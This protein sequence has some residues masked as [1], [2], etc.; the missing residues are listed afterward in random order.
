MQKIKAGELIRAHLE[1]VASE[2][3]NSDVERLP[4]TRTPASRAEF[5][6]RLVLSHKSSA[7]P[8]AAAGGEETGEQTGEE[9]EGA[10][11][12]A[13]AFVKNAAGGSCFST[14]RGFFPDTIS[15]SL[16]I[17]FAVLFKGAF[18]SG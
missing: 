2:R 10:G 15:T 3:S 7:F 14:L 12:G 17:I 18:V 13:T 8:P 4:R 6:T 11:G 16:R 1:C 5:M 9:R